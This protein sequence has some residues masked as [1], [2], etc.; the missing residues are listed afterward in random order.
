MAGMLGDMSH[1]ELMAMRDQPG[2]SQGM[3]APFEHRAFA[4]EWAKESPI[5]AGV[6]LPFAIPAYNVAKKLGMLDAR[7][8]ASMDEVLA[9][10]HGY[11]EGML[12]HLIP[13]AQAADAA[14]KRSEREAE[15]DPR[16]HNIDPR[17]HFQQNL[18][19][20]RARVA[21]QGHPNPALKHLIDIFVHGKRPSRDESTWLDRTGVED[22][23]YEKEQRREESLR[24]H[25]TNAR[26]F[27]T[28]G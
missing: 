22:E 11:A 10:Y 13:S 7:S 23:E 9:G 24:R 27:G 26:F 4:R 12:D 8:P 21:A 15:L 6:S 28:R 25:R 3:L 16:F 20:Y 18:D 1:A 2:A 5:L 17:S 19:A 14:G